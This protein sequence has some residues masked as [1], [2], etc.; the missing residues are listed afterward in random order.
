MF[1]NELV[2]LQNEM[3]KQLITETVLS[4]AF[5]NSQRCIEYD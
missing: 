3:S 4:Y 2:C 1:T 5:I